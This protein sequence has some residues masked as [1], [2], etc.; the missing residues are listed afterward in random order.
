MG[1]TFNKP[2]HNLS[3]IVDSF[4]K[5]SES[6]PMNQQKEQRRKEVLVKDLAAEL[7]NKKPRGGVY[8]KDNELIV[9]T[10]GV[11]VHIRGYMKD[12][13]TIYRNNL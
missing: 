6:G 1:H 8:D 13:F 11:P 3:S 5:I 9:N 4:Y 7:V 12:V 2:E 10:P